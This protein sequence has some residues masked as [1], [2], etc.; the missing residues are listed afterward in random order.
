MKN[1]KIIPKLNEVNA[2]VNQIFNT[3]IDYIKKYEDTY[4]FKRIG[5]INTLISLKLYTNNEFRNNINSEDNHHQQI[6]FL[7]SDLITSKK[8]RNILLTIMN[9][10]I[11][12]KYLYKFLEKFKLDE[13]NNISKKCLLITISENFYTMMTLFNF[14]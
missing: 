3:N 5:P 1:I 10:D 11:P 14:F 8:T 2:Y 13:F 12:I 7:L 6:S 9:I 4:F